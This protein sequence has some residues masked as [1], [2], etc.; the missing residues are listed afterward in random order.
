MIEELYSVFNSEG[1]C[2]FSTDDEYVHSII[3]DGLDEDEKPKVN[4]KPNFEV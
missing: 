3:R 4:I 1:E 2:I